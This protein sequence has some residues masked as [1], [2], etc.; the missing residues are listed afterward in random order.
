MDLRYSGAAVM[1]RD[2]AVRNLCHAV[3]T[4]DGNR[5]LYF[6]RDYPTLYEAVLALKGIDMMQG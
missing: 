5:L 4:I 1:T 2:D 3:D 6:K